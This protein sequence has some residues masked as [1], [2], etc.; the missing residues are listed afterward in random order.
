MYKEYRKSLKI[1]TW[2]IHGLRSQSLADKVLNPDFISE[3][4]D[5][6]IIAVVETHE[7]EQTNMN[8]SGF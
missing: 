1:T 3:I 4:S 6:D 8:I 2:N 5:S 7:H